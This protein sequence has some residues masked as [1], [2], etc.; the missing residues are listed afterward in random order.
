MS[1]G[2]LGIAVEERKKEKEKRE[3]E[4]RKR[5]EDTTEYLLNKHI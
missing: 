2:G 4:E 1:T 5:T 3:G